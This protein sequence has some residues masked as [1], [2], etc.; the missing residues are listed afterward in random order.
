MDAHL[1]D[2]LVQEHG[3]G[4]FAAGCLRRPD[5]SEA[6][7]HAGGVPS[8]LNAMRRH[9]D[10]VNLQRQGCLALRNMAARGSPLLR[11][12]ILDEGAEEVLRHAG[13]FQAS[14]DE[15]YAALRDL[16]LDVG[17][18][19]VDAGTGNVVEDGLVFGA[20]KANFNPVHDESSGTNAAI[21]MAA[22]SPADDMG[23]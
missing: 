14:V 1:G 22:H 21:Q 12:Q 20:K 8:M 3:L 13:R 11:E 18:V 9:P 5:H 16:G 6:L 10:A 15:A 17:I 19:T 4:T 2:A 7:V 23:F